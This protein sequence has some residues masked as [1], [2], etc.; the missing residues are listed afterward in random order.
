MAA[1]LRAD[2]LPGNVKVPAN[3][4]A[5]VIQIVFDFVILNLVFRLRGSEDDDE[6]EDDE[7]AHA[8]SEM[9]E[10][11]YPKLASGTPT[12]LRGHRRSIREP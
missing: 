7:D 12:N 2:G 6:Q 10:R 9:Q 3:V 11:S 5:A 1:T 8:G 4:P